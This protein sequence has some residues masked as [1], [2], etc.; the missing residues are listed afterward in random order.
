MAPSTDETFVFRNAVSRRTRMRHSVGLSAAF[1]VVSA[2]AVVAAFTN[3]LSGVTYALVGVCVAA[4]TVLGT[5][6]VMVMWVPQSVL[7]LSRRGIGYG[8]MQL[9]RRPRRWRLRWAEIDALC[10]AGAHS[11]L[12]AHGRT[13]HITLPGWNLPPRE[14]IEEALAIHLGRYFDLSDGTLKERHAR[15][16]SQW[17]MGRR[18]LNRVALLYCGAAVCA[19]CLSVLLVMQHGLLI[20]AAIL[21]C[22]SLPALGVWIRHER[23]SWIS[24][25]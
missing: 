19:V 6:V 11:R 1:I 22:A 24:R 25:T 16:R 13:Y 8:S 4:N 9:C 20:P 3:P 21:L 23:R 10:W 18:L 17:T 12:R 5:M 14:A 7:R 15:D 2:V